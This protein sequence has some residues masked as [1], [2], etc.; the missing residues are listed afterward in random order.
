MPVLLVSV[1]MLTCQPPVSSSTDFDQ[2]YVYGTPEA[3]LLTTILLSSIICKCFF[4]IYSKFYNCVLFL[5]LGLIVC[6]VLHQRLR[7]KTTK[8]LI[9]SESINDGQSTSKQSYVLFKY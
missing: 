1:L 7:H 3:A 8:R 4:R 9:Y 2:N 5:F 6:L